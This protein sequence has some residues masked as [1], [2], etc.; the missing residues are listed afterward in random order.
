[1]VAHRRAQGFAPHVRIGIHLD[2]AT[3][4]EEDYRGRGV[5][6]AARVGAQAE[7]GEVLVSAATLKAAGLEFEVGEPRTVELKGVS[8]PLELLPI[9][10]S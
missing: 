2:E 5:H 4:D 3:S 1:L 6:V 7:A 8:E 9:A 10:W